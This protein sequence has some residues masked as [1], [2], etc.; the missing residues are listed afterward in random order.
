MISE[1]EESKAACQTLQ[2]N[3]D[4]LVLSASNIERESKATLSEFEKHQQRHQILEAERDNLK[5]SIKELSKEKGSLEN[6]VVELEM[7]K[8]TAEGKAKH[9]EMQVV[10]L[11]N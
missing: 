11:E 3:K 7:Q 8:T 1:I 9:Y 5:S 10:A 4:A 2:W 6:K